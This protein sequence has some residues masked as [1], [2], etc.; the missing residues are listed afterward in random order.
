MKLQEVRNRIAS[1]LH[2]EIG[3]TLSSIS[4][5]S[6]IIQGKLNGANEEVD[7]LLQQVSSNTDNMM[8][9][10]SDIVWTINTRNDR[11]EN[12][13]NRMRAFA[14]EMLEPCDINIEFNVGADV[15]DIQL[16]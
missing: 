5:S 4:I 9:A 13:V 3:S 11:F 16:D 7:K 1:D 2:D 14:I 12:V 10:L 6:T 15:S 8:E